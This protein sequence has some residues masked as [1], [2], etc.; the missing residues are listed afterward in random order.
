[1]SIHLPKEGT[2][3]GTFECWDH[4]HVDQDYLFLGHIVDMSK[5]RD[6]FPEIP[7]KPVVK[8][9]RLDSSYSVSLRMKDHIDEYVPDQD[10]YLTRAEEFKK[11]LDVPSSEKNRGIVAFLATIHS[12]TLVLIKMSW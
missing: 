10:F 2:S 9:V 6:Q 8:I 4:I 11:L 5:R 1:M 3:N 7:E 12:K